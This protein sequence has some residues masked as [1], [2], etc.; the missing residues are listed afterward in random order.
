MPCSLRVTSSAAKSKVSR[1]ASPFA[2]EFRFVGPRADHRFELAAVRR[3]RRRAAVLRERRTL[4]IDE[5]A[6]ACG[7]AC[8]TSSPAFASVPFA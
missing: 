2:R 6:H 4:R 3:E 5:H 1:S 8:S 7:T